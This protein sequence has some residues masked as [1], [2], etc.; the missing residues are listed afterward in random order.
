MLATARARRQAE[1]AIMNVEGPGM[2]YAVNVEIV[3]SCVSS[4]RDQ[5]PAVVMVA[6][7]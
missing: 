5:L 6:A 3:D 7:L 2:P 1:K 4:V